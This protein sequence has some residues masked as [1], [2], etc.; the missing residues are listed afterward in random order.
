MQQRSGDR[1]RVE[2]HVGEFLRDGD[3][4]RNVGFAGLACLARMGLV[5]KFVGS[6]DLL[7]ALLGQV[8]LQR[9]QQA[10]QA[11]VASGRARELGQNGRRVIHV[12]DNSGKSRE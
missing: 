11:V 12:P 2:V 7:H 9:L 5:A 8:G 6:R 3:R 1:L 4:V 10:C